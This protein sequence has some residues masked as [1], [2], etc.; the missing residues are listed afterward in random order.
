MS[1]DKKVLSLK[2]G[3]DFNQPICDMNGT[4]I[5]ATED[6]PLRL[7]SACVNALMGQFEGDKADG[8]VKLKRFNLAQKLGDKD[9]AFP[10]EHLNS[11]QKRLIL[12][13]AE[14]VYMTLLYA[15]IHE[16]LEGTTDDDEDTD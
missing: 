6:E 1:E 7:G 2:E 9:G 5:Q 4:P 12:D 13:M 11:K 10:V 16:A 3:I 8:V 15:R 14:K